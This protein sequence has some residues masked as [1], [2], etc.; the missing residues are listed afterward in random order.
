MTF[1]GFCIAFVGTERKVKEERKIKNSNAVLTMKIERDKRM[2]DCYIK[3]GLMHTFTMY[4]FRIS[5]K[6]YVALLSYF[7]LLSLNAEN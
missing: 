6:F 5:P 2:K 1:Y 3:N 4:F 7:F